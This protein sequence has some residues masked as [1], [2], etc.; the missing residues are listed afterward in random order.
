MAEVDRPAAISRPCDES[1]YGLP[2]TAARGDVISTHRIFDVSF[3]VDFRDRTQ[4]DLLSVPEI[5]N[6]DLKGEFVSRQLSNRNLH[7]S[8]W[9]VLLGALTMLNTSVVLAEVRK[10]T[11][12]YKTVGDLKIQADVFRHDD[13]K[14]RP[15]VVWLHGGALINGHRE[16]IDNRLKTAMLDAGY[17]VVSLDYRLAPETQLPEVIADVEDAFRWIHSKG[18][19]LFRADVKR[20]AVTGGSAGG[21]LTLTCG[22]RIKP[23]PQALVAYWGYGD[24]VG[25]WY[26]DPSPHPAHNQIKVTRE[27]AW[28]QVSGPAIS[29]A[30]QRK[31]NGS[32]FYQYCRQHGAWP[33]AVSGWDP[34]TEPEK[35]YPFMAL[36]NVTPEYPPTLMIHGEIDT[37]V[38]Y[39]QSVLMAA[40]FKRHGV[41]HRLIGLPGGEHGLAGA[42]KKLIDDAH[43]AAHEFIRSHLGKP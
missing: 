40:E 34:K 10:E 25:P 35:F 21:Y 12:T 5:E 18:P 13:D 4:E 20:I 42:D 29:D 30:R 17:I 22:F 9:L 1:T 23:R 37:D 2:W 41:E 15:V 36:K 43:L 3:P 14:L 8:L 7:P 27:E 31:G 32:A 19:D 24:L 11:L 6:I 39:E 28:Q 16:G 26:S 38:P 33:K